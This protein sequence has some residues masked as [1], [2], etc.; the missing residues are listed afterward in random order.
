MGVVWAAA[1]ISLRFHFL[2]FS[3]FFF[4]PAHKGV[5]FS[6]TLNECRHLKKLAKLESA[7]IAN[8]ISPF[9]AL[10]DVVRAGELLKVT[11][12]APLC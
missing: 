12:N 6:K 2:Y 9:C 10:A 8:K 4:T 5:A 3:T 7:K 11:P 1:E